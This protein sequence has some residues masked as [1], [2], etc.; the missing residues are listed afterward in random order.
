MRI[1]DSYIYNNFLRYD[2]ARQKD[3]ARYTNELSSGKRI[4][5]PSDDPLSNAQSLQFKSIKSDLDGY[6]KNLDIVRN[7]QQIAESSLTSIVDSAQEVR[8][9]IVRLSNTGVIDMEDAEILKDYF[10]GMRDYIVNQANT[11]IGDKYLFSGVSSQ[12]A[13]IDANGVYQGSDIETTVPIAKNIEVP[14]R[15][16]GR[17]YLGIDNNDDKMIL[18]KVIDKVVE[19]I[20]NAKN[21]T[22]SLN[23]IN[24]A[25]AITVNGTN[26]NILEGFD[27]GLNSV[28]QYR[29]I[30]GNQNKI[31]E[32][33]K[34]QHEMFKV[35]Y[36]NLISRLED[37]DYTSAISELEKSKVAY[38]ATI[39]SFTQNKDLS[40]L[41]YFK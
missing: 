24:S 6:L 41:K 26:M 38:E 36:S 19:I 2:A 7:T 29:S 15:Y 23:D 30:I 20:D 22:G 17:N 33:I 31:V 40:L 18:V 35:N 27:I 12:N 21:G 1:S 13:P 37:V 4:L 8:A 25:N 28:L 9:E 34:T 11:Q 16:N 3:I 39:A 32:D 5:N 10:V 14:V